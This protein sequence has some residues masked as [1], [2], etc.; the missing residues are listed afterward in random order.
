M[1]DVQPKERQFWVCSFAE[2][3]AVGHQKKLREV[4]IRW[5]GEKAVTFSYNEGDKSIISTQYKEKVTFV[6]L[7]KDAKQG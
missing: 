3:D 1:S 4:H 2:E 5:I 7:V 6:E